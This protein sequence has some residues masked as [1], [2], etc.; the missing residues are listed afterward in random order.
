ML[1]I[2]CTLAAVMAAGSA[3]PAAADPIGGGAGDTRW[4][5]VDVNGNSGGGGG[6]GGCNWRRYAGEIDS[7]YANK[8]DL[9]SYQAAKLPDGTP[10]P[11][12]F[13]WVEC[14]SNTELLYVPD[15]DPVVDPLLMAEYAANFIR[16]ARPTIHVNPGKALV[17]LPTWFWVDGGA[18][19][20]VA[21]ASVINETAVVTARPVAVNWN[22]G[23][24]S[25]TC[26]FPGTAYSSRFSPESPSPDC[27]KVYGRAARGLSVSAAIRYEVTWRAFGAVNTGGTLAPLTGPASQANLDVFEVQSIN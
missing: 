23:A 27:G 12:D 16:G 3:G 1:A 5:R 21:T 19:N 9:P 10:K 17:T 7:S 22:T 26:P 4:I 13:Y 11:G 20:I 8:F 6:A 24:G 2:G 14:G 15:S 18:G 25:L